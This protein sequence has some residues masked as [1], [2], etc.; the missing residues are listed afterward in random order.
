MSPAAAFSPCSAATRGSR[1]KPKPS[2]PSASTRQALAP[3]GERGADVAAAVRC[4]PRPGDERVARR[5]AAAVADERARA[6]QD[7]PRVRRVA[8]FEPGHA[9]CGRVRH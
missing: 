4:A 6:A 1:S 7:E 2:T 9:G 8:R 5:D 3:G